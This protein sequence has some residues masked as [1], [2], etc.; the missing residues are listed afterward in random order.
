MGYYSASSNPPK[1]NVPVLGFI[2]GERK[3]WGLQYDG[4]NWCYK[5]G[6]DR[7]FKPVMKWRP[8]PGSAYE[9]ELLGDANA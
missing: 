5:G 1:I 8:I 6:L 4:H 7:P 9:R 2:K 3:E